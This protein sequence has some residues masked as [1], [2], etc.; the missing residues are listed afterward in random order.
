MASSRS[1]QN[2]VH[3]R[4]S[5]KQLVACHFSRP[6]THPLVW[7]L[8]SAHSSLL[9]TLFEV[10]WHL[11]YNQPLYLRLRQR[12]NEKVEPIF[13]RNPDL[14]IVSGWVVIYRLRPLYRSG[15]SPWR[16]LN[17]SQSG[18]SRWYT[19]VERKFLFLQRIKFRTSR[20]QPDSDMRMWCNH[21][22]FKLYSF[23]WDNFREHL[24]HAVPFELLPFQLTVRPVIPPRLVTFAKRLVCFEL[25]KQSSR[26]FW[27]LM[28]ITI[29]VIWKT[30][31]MPNEL[32]FLSLVFC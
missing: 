6:R 23:L 24:F 27:N 18:P 19:V 15:N 7:N 32:A 30:R 28:T 2:S 29:S 3:F 9:V 22:I 8:S 16:Q 20:L 17:K 12:R 1:Q 10:T 14:G 11:L 5:Y 4:A 31:S 13:N 21:T 26:L 25:V